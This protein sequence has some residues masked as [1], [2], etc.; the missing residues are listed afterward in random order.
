MLTI[1]KV[2]ASTLKKQLQGKV[3]NN[4]LTD[5]FK[6]GRGKGHGLMAIV[7]LYMN[8]MFSP[9]VIHCQSRKKLSAFEKTR[10]TRQET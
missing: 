5:L 4:I 3:E 6:Q 9:H 10:K 2:M 7:I 1:I 8:P